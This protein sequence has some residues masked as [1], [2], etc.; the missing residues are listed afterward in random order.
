MRLRLA[1]LVP[2]L[3]FA[4]PA[5]AAKPVEVT[6]FHTPSTLAQ[7]GPGAIAVVP[8]PGLDPASLEAR[9]WLDAVV[10]ALAARGLAAGSEA[11]PRLAE[12]R[13]TRDIV[14]GGR[15]GSPVSVGLG[16]GGGNWG[17]HSGGSVG[18]GLGFGL[19][20]GGRGEQI[21]SE[22]AVVIRDAR[23]RAPLWEGRAISRARAG[24]REAAPGATAE[25]LAKALFTGFPGRSGET[26]E[27]R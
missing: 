27:V 2:A 19:G 22:L 26:I 20:G 23:T 14:E 11:A 9:T 18:L 13:L 24:S 1:V 4:G 6:R 21:E 7:L 10:R 8:A 16:V 15:R 5:L 12:V 3:L 17:R 25:R